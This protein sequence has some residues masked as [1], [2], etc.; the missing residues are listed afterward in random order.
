MRSKELPFF[1]E[2]LLKR[3]RIIGPIFGWTKL[4]EDISEIK[5]I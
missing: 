4:Y 3:F 5:A 1:F 2:G